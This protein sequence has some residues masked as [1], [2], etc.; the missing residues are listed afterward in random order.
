MDQAY[1]GAGDILGSADKASGSTG[2]GEDRPG[3]DLG[4]K[5]KDTG[6]GGK[7]TATEGI[8]GIGTKG[9]AGG[10]SSYGSIDGFGDKTTVAIQAGGSEESFEGSIDKDAVR[11]RITYNLNLIRGC[12]NQE[13]NRL[14]KSGRK[15]LEGKVVLKWEIVNN[16]V[17]KNVRVSSSTLNN[18]E[19]EKCIS[20]RLATIVFPDPPKD[21]T[22][23]VMYPFVFRNDK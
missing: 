12:Y 9:R 7:G 19:I 5:F 10:T 18:R 17:A 22:A 4:S 21:T 15:S 2:F 6:R 3:E 11:R 1:Q 20:E 14:D 16:G 8:S 23:E 13:L